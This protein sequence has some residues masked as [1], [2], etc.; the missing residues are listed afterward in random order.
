[1][2]LK[3]K[4]PFLFGYKATSRNPPQHELVAIV[5]A[6]Y[7]L[8]ANEPLT[9]ARSSAVAG[10]TIDVLAEG[11]SQSANDLEDALVLLGQGNLRADEFHAGDEERQ[12]ELLYASDFADFKI[13]AEILVRASCYP[14]TPSDKSTVEVR[15]GDWSKE[16]QVLGTHIWL[17]RIAGG[18]T[19]DIQPFGHMAVDYAHAYGGPDFAANPVGKGHER[20]ESQD[21]D[22]DEAYAPP[23]SARSEVMASKQASNIRYP[24]GERL[25]DGQPAG[26]GPINPQWPYRLSKLG[27]AYDDHWRRYRAPY[28]PEDFDWRYFHAAPADQQFPGYLDGD[29]TLTLINLHPKTSKLRTQLPA[30]RLR[31]F[32]LDAQEQAREVPMHLDT[33]FA[34]VDDEALYLTWRGLSP[35]QQADLSDIQYG[36]LAMEELAEPPAP[37]ETYEA[38]LRKFAA[39]P[40]GMDDVMPADFQNAEQLLAQLGGSEEDVAKLLEHEDADN[41][42]GALLAQLGPLA[43]PVAKA[44]KGPLAM[45]LPGIDAG[46]LN[47]SIVAAIRGSQGPTANSRSALNQQLGKTRTSLE[48]QRSVFGETPEIKKAFEQLD[49]LRPETTE[50]DSLGPGAQLIGEDLSGR[51]LS[52]MDLSGAD[53]SDAILEGTQ[54]KN[55]TLCGCNLEGAQLVGADLSGADLSGANLRHV[56]ASRS[57]FVGAQLKGVSLDMSQWLDCDL[58]DA[59]LAESSGE[60]ITISDSS[61]QRVDAKGLRLKRAT[62]E[63]SDFQDANLDGAELDSTGFRECNATNLKLKQGQLLAASFH[64]CDLSGSCFDGSVGKGCAFSETILHRSSFEEASFTLSNFFGAHATRANFRSAVLALSR[65]D[66]AV[67]SECSFEHAS[68]RSA[69]L[70][71]ATLDK[72]DFSGAI[73][74]ESDLSETTGKG[75]IWHKS[76]QTRVCFE[77]STVN[78]P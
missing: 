76:R 44:A 20:R 33:V 16:L 50:N 69:S 1:M 42:I 22:S 61:F 46:E 27:A 32:V 52:N 23:R 57:L 74:F 35:A 58:Q 41:P 36:Y 26:F 77:R 59:N 72:V 49:S 6:K 31:L 29:E 54:L 24:K 18:H 78:K 65:L 53:L 28:Y 34:D 8:K 75:C 15:L 71:R 39:D 37:A 63:K 9:L 56:L 3:N 7:W 68:L 30:K 38:L 64:K 48:Q 2:L 73:L 40:V 5:R 55:A 45:A 17:D 66:K 51:D 25:R 13:G 67:L 14:A 4:T 21:D 12:G 11:Q 19:S 62:I 60:T 47:A 43:G 70:L 10:D